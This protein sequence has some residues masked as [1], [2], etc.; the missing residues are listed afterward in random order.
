MVRVAVLG[1]GVHGEHARQSVRRDAGRRGG[2]GLRPESRSRRAA[3]ARRSAR[4]GRTICRRFSPTPASRRSISA[5]PPRSTGRWPRPRS[6]P[7]STSCSRSRSPS[8]SRMPRRSCAANE[9]T[10]RVFM[11][12]HVLRFWPEYV[13]IA[14]RVASGELGRPRSG[15]ASRRQPFPAWSALF[16]RSDLTG[17]AVIDMMIH[18]YDALNWIFGAPQAVTARGDAQLALRR[19]RSGPGAD[20]LRRWRLRPR[21]RR[22]DDAGVV[23]LLLAPRSAVRRGRDGVRLPRRRPQRRDGRR[24]QRADPLPERG[25]PAAAGPGPGRSLRRRMRL[26]RRRHPP[27]QQPPTAPPRPTRC[28]RWPSRSPRASRWSG[29]GK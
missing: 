17:G 26:L 9:E 20:R 16:S 18:D 13:E 5:C 23:P 24:G 22:H 21:R 8:R 7:A 1:R 25:R 29:A 15:F 4:A 6:P 27:R 12:A 3:G 11:I 2:G 28:R 10:D 14:R 19:V